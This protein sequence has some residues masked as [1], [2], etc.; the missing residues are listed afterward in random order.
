MRFI[1][2]MIFVKR[3]MMKPILLFLAVFLL[4]NA[5]GFS[6][7]IVFT[8]NIKNKAQTIASFGASG[9]WFS[10]GIGKY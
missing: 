8:I 7:S 3:K 9:A 4:I 5:A 6:Q 10:E 1:L 2:K